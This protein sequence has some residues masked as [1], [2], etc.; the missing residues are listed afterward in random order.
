MKLTLI[1]LLLLFLHSSLS[2]LSSGPLVSVSVTG[3]NAAPEIAVADNG[4]ALAVWSNFLILYKLP[5]TTM[6]PALGPLSTTS[7]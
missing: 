3:N 1:L 6:Q 2:A 7:Q 5:T 4:Y